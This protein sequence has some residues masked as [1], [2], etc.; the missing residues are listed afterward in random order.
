METIQHDG[1][2]IEVEQD[3]DIRSPRKE[4]DNLGT[5]VAFHKRYDLGDETPYKQSDF[6]AWDELLAA[7]ER[8]HDPAVVLPVYLYDHSGLAVS[9]QPF[10]CPWDSGQVGFIFAPKSKVRENFGVKR[11]TDKT[12]S[13]ARECLVG[14]VETLNQYLRGDVWCY[15][16]KDESGEDV[17]SCCGMYGRDYCEKEAHEA[18]AAHN[19][20]RA[21]K[22]A[23]K[24]G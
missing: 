13:K 22:L 3:Q 6:S 21:G 11:L 10:H 2:T 16:V 19:S 9:T 24:V 8:D 20:R 15:S 5:L 23:A 18:A 17:D 14:E 1:Y 4:F 12:I 7:I